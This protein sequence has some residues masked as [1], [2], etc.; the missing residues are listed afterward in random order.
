MTTP[1]IQFDKVSFDFQT[2]NGPLRVV[3]DVSLEI[4]E[5][6]FICIV[7]PSGCGKTTLMNLLAGFAKPTE[8]SLRLD[9]NPIQGPGRDRG[10]QSHGQGGVWPNRAERPELEHAAAARRAPGRGGFH[11]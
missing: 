7:G 1:R 5:N 6:E 3:D 8:G 11:H 2:E 4:R 10:G 9:G